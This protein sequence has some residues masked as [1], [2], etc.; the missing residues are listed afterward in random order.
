[1]EVK[2]NLNSIIKKVPGSSYDYYANFFGNK[3]ANLLTIVFQIVYLF[4][5]VLL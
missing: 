2:H 3:S 4:G 5:S 1:M